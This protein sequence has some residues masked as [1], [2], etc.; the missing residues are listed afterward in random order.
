MFV[1]YS[2]VGFYQA[3]S[4]TSDMLGYEY[5]YADSRGGGQYKYCTVRVRTLMKTVPDCTV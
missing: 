1:I 5:E 3:D 4:M 2:R